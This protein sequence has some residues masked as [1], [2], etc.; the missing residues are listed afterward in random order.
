MEKYCSTGT[1]SVQYEM[2]DA[3]K[4]IGV[5]HTFTIYAEAGLGFATELHASMGITGTIAS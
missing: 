3:L 5:E 1:V 2:E 4:A